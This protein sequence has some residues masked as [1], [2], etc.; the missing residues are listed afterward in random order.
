MA[1]HFIACCRLSRSGQ[2]LVRR[3]PR[4]VGTDQ[5]RQI[6]GHL[7]GFD[8]LHTDLLDRIG[9][10]H[11]V[12]GHLVAVEFDDR[13]FTLILFI[14]VLDSGLGDYREYLAA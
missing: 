8:G 4:L 9:E 2:E 14:Q 6:F 7:A 3:E 10:T 13:V 12:G 5:H 1:A 11:H